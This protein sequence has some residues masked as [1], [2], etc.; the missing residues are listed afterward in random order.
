MPCVEFAYIRNLSDSINVHFLHYQGTFLVIVLVV[1]VRV[2]VAHV[3]ALSHT[4][5]HTDDSSCDIIVHRAS[6]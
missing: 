4:L 3:P 1:V 5:Q 6:G 2:V